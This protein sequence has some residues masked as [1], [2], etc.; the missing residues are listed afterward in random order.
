[1][2]DCR[3]CGDEVTHCE[4]CFEA[5]HYEHARD[6]YECAACEKSQ[7]FCSDACE[8][9]FH[10]EVLA[11]QEYAEYLKA[12]PPTCLHVIPQ[13]HTCNACAWYE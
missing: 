11:D 1:M 10:R 2:A 5:K 4:A 13:P 9:N 6:D 3:N 7:E 12:N 8:T